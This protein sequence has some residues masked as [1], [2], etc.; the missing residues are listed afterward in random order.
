MLVLFWKLGTTWA[1][2][3]SQLHAH[4]CDMHTMTMIH[5]LDLGHIGSLLTKRIQQVNDIGLSSMIINKPL[6]QKKKVVKC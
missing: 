5:L 1:A 3:K 2:V 4:H 6:L